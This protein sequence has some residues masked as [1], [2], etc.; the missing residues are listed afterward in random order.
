MIGGILEALGG[1]ELLDPAV[2]AQRC[3][4]VISS[5]SWTVSLTSAAMN[6][7]ASTFQRSEGW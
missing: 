1:L 4:E 5:A 6:L 3:R 7:E 2:S